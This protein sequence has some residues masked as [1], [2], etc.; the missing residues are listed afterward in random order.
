MK[1]LVNGRSYEVEL[2]SKSAQALTFKLDGRRYKV[3]FEKEL[4]KIERELVGKSSRT[5][6]E[7]QGS[8]NKRSKGS[9]KPITQ[10]SANSLTAPIPGVITEVLIAIGDQVVEGEVLMHLEAMKMQNHIKAMADGVVTELAV[11]N[12]DEVSEGQLL[13]VINN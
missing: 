13:V 11:E 12:G 6:K 7:G 5:R 1:L 2:E 4:P 3:S 9:K 8:S 10:T